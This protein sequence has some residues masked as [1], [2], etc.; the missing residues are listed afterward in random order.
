MKMIKHCKVLP[1]GRIEFQGH[2]TFRLPITLR[3][4]EE[5]AIEWIKNC[6]PKYVVYILKGKEY[7]GEGG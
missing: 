4:D 6:A 5:N 2:D 3:M 7:T 1:D